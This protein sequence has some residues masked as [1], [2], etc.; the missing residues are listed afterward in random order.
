MKKPSTHTIMIISLR[1]CGGGG[2]A[3]G[4]GNLFM[5]FARYFG[6]GCGVFGVV[7]G[8]PPLLPPVDRGGLG[9]SGMSL[10]VVL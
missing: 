2:F 8:V 4:G 9:L 5:I 6:R 10:L 1:L 3:S 7:A